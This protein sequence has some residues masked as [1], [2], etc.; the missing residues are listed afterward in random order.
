MSTVNLT[1]E[2][3]ADAVQR[4]GITLID[5]WAAWCG[6][7]RSFAPV[8]EAASTRHPDIVFAKVDVDAQPRLAGQFGIAS[9]PT[10]M[11][12]KDGNLVFAQPGALPPAILE[13][14]ISAVR[15]LDLTKAAADGADAEGSRG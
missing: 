2:T 15:E 13:R 14:L 4:P 12:F 10:L 3:F 1:E 11:A 9:I 5:W 7:C 8:Y 6:P